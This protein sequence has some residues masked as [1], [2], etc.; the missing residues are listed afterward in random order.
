ML[1][2]EDNPI[3]QA[4][5]KAMLSKLG[6]RWQL[7]KHGEE[8]VAWVLSHDF[9][10]VLMDCQM[11]VMDGFEATAA[12]RS[13]PGG[14]GASLPIVALTANA[15]QGDEQRCRD[16]GMDGF[17]AK[18]YTLAQL[19]GT[20]SGW[21]ATAPVA[22][23]AAP[24]AAPAINP[25][26]IG[27]L[28]ELDEPGSQTLVS[29]LV[30][31]FLASADAQLAL[32]DAA[33]ADGQAKALGKLAH[34]MKSSSANLGADAL[35]ACYRELERFAREGRM[36]DAPPLIERLRVE[37]RRAVLELRELLVEPA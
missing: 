36:T 27:M 5:A 37:Q 28:R 8:A 2:V 26:S 15:L 9:D 12:I 4:V 24:P 23:E 18:P 22:T 17:L 32:L 19:H 10:L 34:A 33:V 20:L 29:Q 3:N 14:R 25:R 11:P 16:A 30:T 7:A 6:L 13:L 31:M 21:L 35:S 1:L